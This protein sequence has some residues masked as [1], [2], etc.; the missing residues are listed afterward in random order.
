MAPGAAA[1]CVADGRAFAERVGERD[2]GRLVRSPSR[3]QEV[4]LVGAGK[5][6]TLGGNEGQEPNQ[7]GPDGGCHGRKSR[8]SVDGDDWESPV[9]IGADDDGEGECHFF[10]PALD[11]YIQL[12]H[13]LLSILWRLSAEKV[14]SYDGKPPTARRRRQKVF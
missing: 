11:F 6:T 3:D 2:E 4:S 5:G 9:S 14:P 13:R 8:Q 1:G 12:L 7:H 10:W